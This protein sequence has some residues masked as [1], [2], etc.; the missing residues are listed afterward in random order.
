MTCLTL[1]MLLTTPPFWESPVTKGAKIRA[2][3]WDSSLWQ[4]KIEI[5]VGKKGE[6]GNRKRVGEKKGKKK[7]RSRA[8]PAFLNEQSY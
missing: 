7:K 8:K 6:M 5:R 4:K 2:L 1:E 3:H